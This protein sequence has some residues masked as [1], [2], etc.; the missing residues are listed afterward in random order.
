MMSKKL[1]E[2]SLKELWRLFPI[3][4][5]EHNDDWVRWYDSEAEYLSDILPMQYVKRIS[6]IGSTSIKRIWAK[7]I[8]DIL[9]ELIPG[10]DMQVVKNILMMNGYLCMAESEQRIS[11]NKGYTEAGFA[12]KVFH[13]HLRFAGDND[14]LYFRDYLNEH[15]ESAQQYEELKLTLWK[16]YENNRDAYTDAK[17]EFVGK[18]M[19]LAKLEFD[20]G[21]SEKME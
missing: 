9:V 7:P 2:M 16:Q 11:F 15:P 5:T 20:M 1:T 21:T 14:E 13:L 18:I 19:K 3:Y 10:C 8:V 4:L 6:H 17:A 12:E